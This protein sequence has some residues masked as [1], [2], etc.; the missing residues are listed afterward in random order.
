M[1]FLRRHRWL[2]L[3]GV[4]LGLLVVAA[5]LFQWDWLIPLVNRQ[6]SAALGRP[7]TITHLHVHL[8]RTT[9][10]E[11]DGITVANPADWPG[12]GNFA[13]IERLGLDVL[14]LDYIQHHQ[15]TLPVIDVQSPKLDAQQL[16]DGRANWTFGSSTP[17]APSTT[18]AP[19]LGTLRIA[20]GHAHVRDAKLKADFN[21]DLE[22]KETETGGGKDGTGQIV[23]EAKGTYAAQPITAQFVGGALLSLRDAAKP[24]PVDLKLANGPTRVSLQGTVQDPLSFAGADLKLELSGPDMALLLPLTGIAIPKTPAYRIAGKLDYSEGVV[25]FQQFTGKVG[26]SDLAGSIEVDTKPEHRPA[27]TADLQ[28]KLVD[29]RDLGGFIGAEP[30]DADKGTKKV[31]N[32]TGRILPSDPISLP[33]L[34]VADVHL[35]YRAG[36]IEGRR[37]PLDNM[38]ADLDIVNG[39]VHLHPLSFGIGKGQI[40][41]DIA[42]AETGNQLRAKATVDF[43]RVDVDKLLTATGVGRGAGAIGGRMVID[44]TGRSIADILG[45]GNGELKLYMGRG[46]NLS[47]LLV[48]ISGLEFGNAFLSAIGVPNRAQVE[49]LITDFVLQQGVATARTVMLDTDE[50]R[51]GITGDVNLRNETLALV[52]KTE[53][54]HFSIGSLPTPIDIK[55]TL[56]SPG[57]APEIGPLAAR[58]GAAVA[59][60]I[61]ATPLAALLPTIQLGTGEDGACSG[62]LRTAQAPPRVPGPAAA[63]ARPRR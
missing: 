35:K 42:L 26:S 51:I 53:A 33:K 63:P 3:S 13:T 24:Y 41:S 12:G 58:A 36:R 34:N 52:T 14:P 6:A 18:P 57:I 32:T 5:L 38:R 21:I 31:A 7:V 17:A 23:A 45:R 9:R 30:G 59:L 29:L 15:V 44:G 22:T 4:L 27:L 43:Q 56:A 28:S 10:V 25:K 40:V 11:A 47:A 60:G 50:A 39:D 8:G 1:T 19:R 62:L 61:I 49:C 16:P 48:D 46:G 55:G 2:T 54:K 20:D 37:Q